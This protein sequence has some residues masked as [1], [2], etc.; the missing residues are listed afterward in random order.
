MAIL[1]LL[2]SSKKREK[3]LCN[4]DKGCEVDVEDD[5]VVLRSWVE[6]AESRR[7]VIWSSGV[8]QRRPAHNSFFS[9][10]ALEPRM[11]GRESRSSS[12]KTLEF[13]SI[14][15]LPLLPLLPLLLFH[16]QTH[17]DT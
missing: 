13:S 5:V 2:F 9:L 15:P 8:A 10:P 3:V 17:L 14:E 11:K 6:D 12:H 7:H 16:W 4:G 1:L